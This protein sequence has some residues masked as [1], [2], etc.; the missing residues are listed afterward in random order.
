MNGGTESAGAAADASCGTSSKPGKKS[1]D[2][3][4]LLPGFVPSRCWIGGSC[5]G[6]GRGTESGTF[7]GRKHELFPES[8]GECVARVRIGLRHRA[9]GHFADESDPQQSERP[10]AHAQYRPRA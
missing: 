8:L 4:A 2:F 10:G 6:S 3:M 5:R 1:M 9:G 7:P